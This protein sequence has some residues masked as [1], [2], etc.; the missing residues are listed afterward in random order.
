MGSDNDG[1]IQGHDVR[2]SQDNS[3]IYRGTKSSKSST[4]GQHSVK[5]ILLTVQ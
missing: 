5:T 2:V 3:P 4:R 1:F